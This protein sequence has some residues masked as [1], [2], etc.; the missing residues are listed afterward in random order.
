MSNANHST[1]GSISFT[2]KH[3]RFSSCFRSS[4]TS[5]L[6]PYRSTKINP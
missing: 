6:K 1:C 2:L 4:S 3:V 5:P